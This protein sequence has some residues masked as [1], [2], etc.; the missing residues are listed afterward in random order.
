MEDSTKACPDGLLQSCTTDELTGGLRIHKVNFSLS[1]VPG[2]SAAAKVPILSQE[3]QL[4]Q[5]MPHKAALATVVDQRF[6]V[7][8]PKCPP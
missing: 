5:K 7:T 4:C 3:E 6:K 8:L 2:Y 1:T